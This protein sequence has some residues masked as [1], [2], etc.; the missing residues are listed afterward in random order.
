MAKAQMSETRTVLSVMRELSNLEEG[1]G[2]AA[3][4]RVVGHLYGC[5]CGGLDSGFT[6]VV[7]CDEYRDLSEIKMCLCCNDAQQLP[8]MPICPE[9][10]AEGVQ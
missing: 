3:V 1:C 5:I 2:E 4:K 6:E 9:C 10:A 7:E 8:Y